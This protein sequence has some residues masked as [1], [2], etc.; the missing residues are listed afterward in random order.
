MGRLE[1]YLYSGY[2]FCWILFN[3]GLGKKS[4]FFMGYALL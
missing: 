4:D 3:R 1:V 2:E